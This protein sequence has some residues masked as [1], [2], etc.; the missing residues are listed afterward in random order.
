[1]NGHRRLPAGFLAALVTIGW[2]VATTATPL[3][4]APAPTATHGDEPAL[5]GHRTIVVARAVPEDPETSDRSVSVIDAEELAERAPRTTPEALWETPGVFVQ[6]TNRGGGSPFIRGL[7]GPQVLIT[8]DGVRLNNSTYRTGPLQYLHLVDA[9]SLDRIEILRGSG[10]VLHGSD[11]MGGVLS[12]HPVEPADCRAD[13]GGCADGGIRGGISSADLGGAVHARLGG[14]IGGFGAV[15][16]ATFLDTRSLDAGGDLG[17][18]PHSGYRTGATVARAVHRFRA[19][20]R[21]SG[22]V[23]GNWLWGRIENAGRTDAVAKGSLRFIDNDVHLAWARL[24]LRVPTTRAEATLSYQHFREE[25]RDLS[26]AADRRTATGARRDRVR[27]GTIGTDVRLL[28]TLL[29]RRLQLHYGGMYYRDAVDSDKAR[30]GADARFHPVSGALYPDGSLYQTYGAYVRLEGDPISTA[31]GH[32]L[33]LSGGY[34]LHGMAGSAPDGSVLGDAAWDALG[35]VGQAGIQ[36]LWKDRMT[37]ALTWSEG[38]RA[39]S[40]QEAA[41]FGDVG[42]YWEV[43]NPNLRA[44]RSDTLELLARTRVWRL[45]IQAAGWATFLSDLIARAPGTWQGQDTL[46]GKTVVIRKNVGR[47]RALGVEVQADLDVGWG[48][49]VGGNLAWTWGEQEVDGGPDVPMSRIPPIFGT[50]RVR[51]DSTPWP[52]TLS[53]FV[54]AYV[55]A[56]GKQDRLAPLDL[57]DSRIPTDGTPGWTT[58]NLRMG[59]SVAGRTRVNLALEN[60][61]DARYKH[62]GSGIFMPGFNAVLSVA[63][64]L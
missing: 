1:M 62:H 41:V 8:V 3:E 56:A 9:F 42:D 43:P 64:D 52:G 17:R 63:V 40:L 20:P 25:T 28:T 38:F 18:Q 55:R 30:Q 57:K 46:D 11:A 35:H 45:R 54:E 59:M 39:P 27:A 21:V 2:V 49:S 22:S 34:R 10:S 53:G 12:L 33:R 6:A 31:D 13:E 15:A 19:G 47:A 16:G 32:V 26:L 29:D 50:A 14:G 4:D 24:V 37:V 48:V 51:W 44:E 36:W 23:A 58:L 5:P 61:T 60:L 7:V